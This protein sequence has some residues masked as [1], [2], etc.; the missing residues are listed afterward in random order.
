MSNEIRGLRAKT[1]M[2]DDSSLQ[3]ELT[4][5][6]MNKEDTD[7]GIEVSIDK[8]IN[9]CNCLEKENRELKERLK[10]REKQLELIREQRD[11]IKEITKSSENNSCKNCSCSRGNGGSGFCHCTIGSTI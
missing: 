7:Y 11:I 10:N 1:S 2:V 5:S 4:I 6:H 9:Y 3:K 8:L